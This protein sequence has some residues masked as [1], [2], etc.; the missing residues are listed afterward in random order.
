MTFCG[1]MSMFVKR[2]FM[3]IFDTIFR[4][5]NQ[6][7]DFNNLM[8]DYTIDEITKINHEHLDSTLNLFLKPLGFTM[9]DLLTDGEKRIKSILFFWGVCDYAIEQFNASDKSIIINALSK[10]DNTIPQIKDDIFND[11][12]LKLIREKLTS[13]GYN[14][15]DYLDVLEILSDSPSLDLMSL[16]TNKSSEELYEIVFLGAN[17]FKEFLENPKQNSNKLFVFRDLIDGRLPNGLYS[18][19]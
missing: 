10:N 7:D 2:K 1:M 16:T 3:G 6:N 12:R 5:K 11:F 19:T 18:V 13:L 17:I 14:E 8:L 4:K 15:L 9:N